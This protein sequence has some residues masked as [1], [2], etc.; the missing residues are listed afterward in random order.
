MKKQFPIF[1][2]YLFHAILICLGFFLLESYG[3][4]FFMAAATLYGAY[5][6]FF[7]IVNHKGYMPWLLFLHHVLGAAIEFLLHYTGIIPPDSGFFYGLLQFLYLCSIPFYL[8]LLAVTNL[9]LFLLATF[10]RKNGEL[11]R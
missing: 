1:H 8:A 9:I 2:S 5:L 11:L 10:R 3:D 4:A 6:I 7:I